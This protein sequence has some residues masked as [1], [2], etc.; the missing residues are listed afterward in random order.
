[1]F[2][3]LNIEVLKCLESKKGITMLLVVT[4]L[5]S[6]MAIGLGIF[7]VIFGQIRISGEI[8]DSFLAFYSADQGIEKTLYLDRITYVGNT[9][10][11]CISTPGIPCYTETGVSASS[12]GCYDLSVSKTTS[13]AT[14]EIKV[15]GQYRCGTNPSRII[16][17]GFNLTY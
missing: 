17:R 2:K 5:S 4:I 6:I 3:Y 1:M 7:N 10:G 16:R 8:A 11:V 12:G 13:P 9:Y 14:T 15:L